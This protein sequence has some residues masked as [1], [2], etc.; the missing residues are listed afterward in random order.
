MDLPSDDAAAAA[1][2]ISNKCH[3]ESMVKVMDS[4]KN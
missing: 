4:A 1:A 3:R 2:V